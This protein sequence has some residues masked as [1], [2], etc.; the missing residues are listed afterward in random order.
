[1]SFSHCKSNGSVKALYRG[2][3][4]VHPDT[5]SA[6]LR[7]ISDAVAMLADQAVLLCAILISSGKPQLC[8]KANL[9]FRVTCY[10]PLGNFFVGMSV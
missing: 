4:I 5:L 2:N 10:I 8:L 6:L 3:H 1:M 9:C 7:P